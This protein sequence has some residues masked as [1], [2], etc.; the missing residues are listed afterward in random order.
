MT[1]ID[2]ASDHNAARD[3][4]AGWYHD[5]G[6]PD[7]TSLRWWNGAAWSEH[8]R[9]VAMASAPPAAPSLAP[10]VVTAPPATAGNAAAALR[11]MHNSSAW[12]SFGFGVVALSIASLAFFGQRTSILISSSGVFAI[13]S[14][15][16]ALRLRSLGVATAFVPAVLGLVFGALGTLLM[17]STLF[18]V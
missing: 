9:P 17:L 12:W 4:Q 15:V 2:P 16:R 14:G 11:V 5:P 6:S 10:R 13:I 18:R 7:G 8:T 1:A 3:P